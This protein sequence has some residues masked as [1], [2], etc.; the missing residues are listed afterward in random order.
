MRWTA[1][2][3]SPKRWAGRAA[4]SC[5]VQGEGPDVPRGRGTPAPVSPLPEREGPGV[6]SLEAGRKLDPETNP[7]QT[8][9]LQRYPYRSRTPPGRIPLRHPGGGRDP[10]ARRRRCRDEIAATPRQDHDR[11]PEW[12][13]TFVRMTDMQTCWQSIRTPCHGGTTIGEG[14]SPLPF[15]LGGPPFVL[16]EVE[17]RAASA[18]HRAVLRLRPGRTARRS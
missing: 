6:G 3:A 14:L 7:L 11:C 17:G 10:F 16:S 5:L 12:I 9:P 8:L 2:A 1:W 18:A 13:L 4:F 15:V